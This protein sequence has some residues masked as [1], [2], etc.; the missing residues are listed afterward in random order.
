MKTYYST[1][2]P[3]SIDIP[4]AMPMFSRSSNSMMLLGVSVSQ[5]HKRRITALLINKLVLLELSAGVAWPRPLTNHIAWFI[6]CWKYS[7]QEKEV[8]ASLPWVEE[9]PSEVE[10]GRAYFLPLSSL[11]VPLIPSL[12]PSFIP[13]PLL[14]STLRDVVNITEEIHVHKTLQRS[15]NKWTE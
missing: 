10:G 6:P 14:Q 4:T 8:D 13:V 15:M 1:C 9:S 12:L 3:N 11:S 5:P 7:L 2:R